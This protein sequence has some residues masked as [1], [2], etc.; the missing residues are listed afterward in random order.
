MNRREPGHTPHTRAVVR[1]LRARL[2]PEGYLGFH[3]TVGM[4]LIILAFL[5]FYEIGEDYANGWLA[6]M[7][8]NAAEFF[9]PL[10]T[11]ALTRVVLAVTFFGSVGAVT[12][13]S[14]IVGIV[15]ILKRSLYRFA[16]FA[17]TIAGGRI[18]AVALKYLF[19]R[20]R[21]APENPIVTYASYAFP[22]GHTMGTTLLCGSLAIIGATAVNGFGKRAGFFLLA[23]VWVMVIGASRIYLGAH[24]LTDVIGG[25]TAGIAWLALCWTA[26]ETLRRWRIRHHSF[27]GRGLN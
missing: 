1:F 8:R 13:L 11:P 15:L 19:A 9:H 24:Y 17:L 4:L 12:T 26:V 27:A 25:M 16:A 6:Q 21:P 2:S 20:A 5:S 22:S 7:D 18:L 10:M 3:L 14:V 23:A